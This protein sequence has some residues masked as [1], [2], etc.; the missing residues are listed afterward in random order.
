[1]GSSSTRTAAMSGATQPVQWQRPNEC[2]RR[3][4]V[5]RP[6]ATCMLVGAFVACMNLRPLMSSL[7]AF[8]APP[9]GDWKS[10]RSK[11]TGAATSELTVGETVQGTVLRNLGT[12]R[13]RVDIGEGREGDLQMSELRDGFPIESALLKSGDEV[14]A[15]ILYVKGE[16]KDKFRLTMRSG[17]L[18]RPHWEH[19]RLNGRSVDSFASVG[20]DEWFEGPVVEMSAFAVW[21]KLS[22]PG[23]GDP[24]EGMVHKTDFK[25]GFEDEAALGQNVRVRVLRI[26]S[27]KK[28]MDLSMKEP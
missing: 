26:D 9:D 13:Y 2:S 17:D 12:K 25:E 22:P 16:K 15:R 7:A 14:T 24:C 6:L 20:S 18:D 3:G 5:R 28:K 4:P 27:T 21:V 19:R 10:L 8:A 23:G 11:P 1:L